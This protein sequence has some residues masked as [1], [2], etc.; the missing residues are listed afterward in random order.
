M[1]YGARPGKWRKTCKGKVFSV[2]TRGARL[3]VTANKIATVAG[4]VSQA[5]NKMSFDT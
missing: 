3:I 4:V 1:V 2:I 5:P